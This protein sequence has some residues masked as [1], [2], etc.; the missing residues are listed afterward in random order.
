MVET[1]TPAIAARILEGH[2]NIR[3]LSPYKVAQYARIMKA[4]RW[5]ICE[6]I[7]FSPDDELLNG[8]HRLKAV[9][10]ADT[11]VEFN[12]LRNVQ[13]KHVPCID[14]GMPRN[15]G[16]SLESSGLVADRAQQRAT[17]LR[18]FHMRGNSCSRMTCLKSEYPDLY[19][20]YE[21]AIDFIIECFPSCRKGA[22]RAGIVSPWGAAFLSRPDERSRLIEAAGKFIALQF[23]PNNDDALRFLARYA[24]GQSTKASHVQNVD[25]RKSSFALVKWL[26]REPIK[27]LNPSGQDPFP[28]PKRY[29]EKLK[30]SGFS[31]AN[32]DEELVH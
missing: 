7:I 3:K 6:P 32:Q 26:D 18:T 21:P 8:Q 9:I 24:T 28:L 22:T 16:V 5:P 17:L 30:R 27:T 11:S 2:K 19:K 25:Y 4:G 20:I 29:A 14:Q 12:V 1:I 10:E 31:V 15:G 13:S 23:D